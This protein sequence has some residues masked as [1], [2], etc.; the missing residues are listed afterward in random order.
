MKKKLEKL[1]K[2]LRKIAFEKK[3]AEHVALTTTFS[4]LLEKLENQDLPA[5]SPTLLRHPYHRDKGD[6]RNQ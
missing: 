2:N 4:E 5:A 1:L 3:F 6:K